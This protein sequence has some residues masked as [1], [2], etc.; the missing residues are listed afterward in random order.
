MTAEHAFTRAAAHARR[1]ANTSGG[2]H[3]SSITSSDN[4]RP[5]GP[6]SS[7]S[8][9]PSAQDSDLKATESP[10][11]MAVSTVNQGG[12]VAPMNAQQASLPPR[13]TT[14]RTR[15]IP[16]RLLS[17]EPSALRVSGSSK[18]AS[19]KASATPAT[20]SVPQSTPSKK[21]TRLGTPQAPANAEG[22][23]EKMVRIESSDATGSIHSPAED[24]GPGK[25]KRKPSS[26]S[27]PPSTI[28]SP[29]LQTQ[30]PS[31]APAQAPTPTSISRPVVPRIKVRLSNNRGS[32]ELKASASPE[33]S[34]PDT[35]RSVSPEK[36]K[37]QKSASSSSILRTS[38]AASVLDSTSMDYDS[39]GGGIAT[40]AALLA[41]PDE[42]AEDSD[43]AGGDQVRIRPKPWHHA[44][45]LRV[46]SAAFSPPSLLAHN[47]QSS[48][49]PS[50]PS[51]HARAATTGAAAVDVATGNGATHNTARRTASLPLK[52]LAF[53]E[54]T[55]R[56]LNISS[57][58][59]DGEDEE[60]NDFHKI[61]LS[62]G[63]QDSLEGFTSTFSPKWNLSKGTGSSGEEDT[64]ATTPRSPQSCVELPMTDSAEPIELET[65]PSIG[66]DQSDPTNRRQDSEKAEPVDSSSM[67][68]DDSVFVHALPPSSRRAHAHAGTL[69]LSLPFEEADVSMHSSPRLN[70]GSSR[71]ST[72]LLERRAQKATHF[73][74]ES[75]DAQSSDP[76][77]S[78]EQALL[79]LSA[80]PQA[81]SSSATASPFVLPVGIPTSPAPL[82]LP[83]TKDRLQVEDE[84]GRASPRQALLKAA[85]A[86]R[87]RSLLRNS[88]EASW[89]NE[90]RSISPHS[91][92]S[93]RMD[94]DEDDVFGPP[95]A[96]GLSE[97]DRAWDRDHR[98]RERS[99]QYVECHSDNEVTKSSAMIL[100]PILRRPSFANSPTAPLKLD[101]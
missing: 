97:L 10:E 1:I 79:G 76:M 70:L 37:L 24:L 69:T 66:G 57:E 86:L 90:S 77:L 62:G 19:E 46:N 55:A 75:S 63:D 23:S 3:P 99:E 42:E 13:R 89:L 26:M 53:A 72:P 18:K 74:L 45:H 29:P 92:L 96:M 8:T 67:S 30:Q 78:P 12:A 54:E 22:S 28:T 101:K 95:E 33:A 59:T 6:Q 88:D 9:T 32:S 82:V 31:I 43:T 83:P 91:S 16:S 80:P 84:N 87:S 35:L 61:M 81:G 2:A 44:K 20:G 68:A 47:A 21:S 5:S 98:S 50:R 49:W 100:K 4:V 60:E 56:R 94:E 48:A 58:E 93:A 64:P 51:I 36:R 40:R 25:R 38:A 17:P 71:G 27:R 41:E 15:K 73:G 34:L 7:L 39:D 65:E 52:R 14:T 11:S 85:A